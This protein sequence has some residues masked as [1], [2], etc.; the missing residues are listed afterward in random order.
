MTRL[1]SAL[2]ALVA[3]LAAGAAHA[4]SF[5]Y[6][7][8][9]TPLV[10]LKGNTAPPAGW[11]DRGAGET[12]WIDSPA[13][14]GIG[15]GDGDDRTILTDMQN[16]Y[17]TVYA[18]S[19]FFV[20]A[21]RAGLTQLSLRARYDDGF[22]AYLNGTE[23]GRAS[24]PAGSLTNQSAA[25]DHEVT[26]SDA[27]FTVDPALLVDGDNVLAVEVH[28]VS[29]GSSDLSF[30]PELL[31]VDSAG[32]S[33]RLVLGPY[34]QQVGRNG[35]TVCWETDLPSTARLAWGPSAAMGQLA[36]SATP[37]LRHEM[38][39]TSLAPS[40]T[41]HYR[42]ES[43]AGPLASGQARTE[44]DRADPLRVVAFGD[45]RTNPADHAAVIAGILS[46]S[47]HLVLHSGDLVESSTALNWATF[48]SVEAPL[49]S[50][51]PLLPAIGNHEGDAILYRE[52]FVLPTASPGGERYY[53]RRFAQVGVLTLDQYD[54]AYGAGSDQLAFAQ[55]TLADFA[56]DPGLRFVFV[57]MHQGAYSSGSHGSNATIRSL[58]APLFEQY[59]VDIVFSGHDHD[60][61]RSTTNG[62]KYVVTGGGGAPLYS[63]PG[64]TWTEAKATTLHYCL[65]E[66]DGAT[67]HFR[68]LTPDGNTTIDEF[69]LGQ[70][71]SECT[72]DADCNSRAPGT[73]DPSDRGEWR[74]VAKACIFNCAVPPPPGPDA[75]MPGAD[76]GVD[77][78]ADAVFDAVFDAGA[79]VG[80]DAGAISTA[81]AN[82]VV[83]QDG[84]PTAGR[85]ASSVAA[86]DAATATRDG[87]ILPGADTGE[88][89][90][91]IGTGCGCNAGGSPTGVAL[92]VAGL[93]LTY[94][95]RP[96][97]R[98]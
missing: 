69:W 38:A 24:V 74:C 67:L 15:Y 3:L 13:G 92:A 39:L 72:A 98:D 18:R 77:A 20:G 9:G 85:D 68:A 76:A 37:A 35:L 45:T 21:E 36:E 8:E 32:P 60:Y 40:T 16:G 43:A 54:S 73:C 96:R 56:A 48:F 87:G 94:L 44:G 90:P 6:V 79:D 97:R 5:V 63:V 50:R 70:T 62:V 7:G 42:V 91:T 84:G 57:Q 59:G 19:H 26:V 53:A 51:Y 66:I 11:Q 95:G 33:A 27:T 30:I 29:L 58:Y 86:A 25:F 71:V 22:V 61:E 78:G 34:V 31:G 65:M 93:A 49:V 23:I 81:D 80:D 89:P 10:Y 88:E 14:F 4:A 83:L 2:V 46:R 55:Q 52:K 47:P 12:S 75:G 41:Y 64:E 28:N 82:A 17:L 1:F